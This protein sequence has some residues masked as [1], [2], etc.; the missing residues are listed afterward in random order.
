MVP[1]RVSSTSRPAAVAG[2]IAQLVREQRRTAVR[3]IG[4]PAVYQALRAVIIAR[5]YLEGD[6]LDIAF[7]PSLVTL[8][9]NGQKCVAIE[10]GIE[11]Y[12]VVKETG[13]CA[14]RQPI[15]A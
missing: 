4:A 6:G 9:I 5:K 7:V 14:P 1:L 12:P 2:A 13:N 11:S 15:R 10:L 8:E 3:V